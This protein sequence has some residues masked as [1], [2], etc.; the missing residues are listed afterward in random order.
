MPRDVLE[1]IVQERNVWAESAIRR[2]WWCRAARLEEGSARLLAFSARLLEGIADDQRVSLWGSLQ[3]SA[4]LAWRAAGDYYRRSG[5]KAKASYAYA[6]A[7]NT[8]PLDSSE[9]K[10]ELRAL[11][12]E[13]IVSSANNRT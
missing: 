7:L 2:G 10:D 4:S 8:Y 6:K 12:D 5:D 3:M 9:T 11:I 13:L 1:A